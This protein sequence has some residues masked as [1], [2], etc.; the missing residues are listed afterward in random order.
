[1]DMHKLNRKGFTLLE[2]LLVIYILSVFSLLILNY[3]PAHQEKEVNV[4]L[5]KYLCLQTKAL[6]HYQHLKLLPNITFNEKGHVNL[7][8]TLMFGKHKLK[9]YLGSGAFRYE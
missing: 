7:A 3:H 1:M 5:N 8:R 2:C 6:T 4:F 9:I